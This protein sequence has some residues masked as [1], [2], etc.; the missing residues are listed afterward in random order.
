MC[1]VVPASGDPIELS[2]M[3]GQQKGCA[4][5]G[6]CAEPKSATVPSSTK[7]SV[8][9]AYQ[10]GLPFYR[11]PENPLR[12]TRAPLQENLRFFTKNSAP[13]QA[14]TPP[15]LLYPLPLKLPRQILRPRRTTQPTVVISVR[16]ASLFGQMGLVLERGAHFHK[17]CVSHFF[18][19]P[20]PPLGLPRPLLR[21]RRTTQPTV[22]ISVR[23][24]SRLAFICLVLERG[25]HFQEVGFSLFFQKSTLPSCLAFP[26]GFVGLSGPPLGGPGAPLGAPMAAF[27]ATTNNA[28]HRRD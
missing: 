19:N 2:E 27:T 5:G 22:V 9:L 8:I 20:R 14:N 11:G 21:P 15:A 13:L 25:A 16:S 4:F 26:W 28:A 6:L 10:R 24:A 18:E 3:G 12:Q 1:T 17:C 7:G 23:S